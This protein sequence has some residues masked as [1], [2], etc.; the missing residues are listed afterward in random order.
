MNYV[1]AI[2]R[3]Q[4]HAILHSNS[5]AFNDNKKYLSK[6]LKKYLVKVN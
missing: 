3:L 1:Q 5:C 2:L 6:Y 4:K